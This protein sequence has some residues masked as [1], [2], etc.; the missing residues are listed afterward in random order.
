MDIKTAAACKIKPRWPHV[1]RIVGPR[2]PAPRSRAA[3]A[4][5]QVG[6]QAVEGGLVD[7]LEAEGLVEAEGREVGRGRLHV[8]GLDPELA[9]RAEDLADE[10]SP[11]AL[12][13]VRRGRPPRRSG[14]GGSGRRGG[15]TSS[16]PRWWRGRARPGRT[17]RSGGN[18]AGRKSP[19]ARFS[20][21]F[22]GRA[23]SSSSSWV[24]RR[25]RRRAGRAARP[26]RGRTPGRRWC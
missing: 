19:R 1:R 17:G 25:I 10:E 14:R 2:G 4:V 16:C 6:R 21:Q 3:G 20:H 12:A 13:A 23:S 7:R 18:R 15:R 9:G 26:G 8:D 22:A 11:V 5:E 24:W